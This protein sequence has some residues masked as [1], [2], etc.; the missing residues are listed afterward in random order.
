VEE[1]RVNLKQREATEPSRPL[2]GGLEAWTVDGGWRHT[3][4]RIGPEGCVDGTDRILTGL[5]FAYADIVTGSPPSGPMNPTVDLQ[6]RLFA[7]ARMG[8]IRFTARTLRLG[9]TLYV[10][11]AEMR[12]GSEEQPFG[13]AV[14]TFVNQPISVPD[15]PESARNATGGKLEGI[16]RLTGFQRIGP[17]CLELGVDLRTPQGTVPGAT[18][19][20]LVEAAATNL[21]GPESRVNELDVRFLNKVRVGPIRAT[22]TAL[23]HRDHDTT[24]RVDIVDVGNNDRLVTFAL[25]VCR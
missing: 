2:A 19:G 14:A 15:L 21:L 12:H 20:L 17:G 24:V 10:G 6:V 23:G 11:E 18:L 1:L 16:G 22:A 5:L 25:A 7:P 9:R 8:L 4:V 3:S 13:L